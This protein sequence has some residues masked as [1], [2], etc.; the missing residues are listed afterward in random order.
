MDKAYRAYEQL[1]PADQLRYGD[2]QAEE[3]LVFLPLIAPNITL[4]D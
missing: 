4:D 3:L 1:S 2:W